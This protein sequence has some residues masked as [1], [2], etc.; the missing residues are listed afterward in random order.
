MCNVINK[1]MEGAISPDDMET[2]LKDLNEMFNGY[3]D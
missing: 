1:A 3:D 2:R